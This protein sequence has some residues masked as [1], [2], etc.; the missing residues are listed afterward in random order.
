MTFQTSHADRRCEHPPRLGALL[1]G[2]AVLALVMGAGVA[3]GQSVIGNG[4]AFQGSATSALGNVTLASTSNTDTLT[5]H[6]ST[7]IV[8]WT[9]YDN[10][11][12]T[13]P[14]S[15]LPR[16]STG[17][18]QNGSEVSGFTVLNR[19]NPASTG[20]PIEF[21]GHVVSQ[22]VDATGAVSRGGNVWFY[23]PGGIIIG[24]TGVFDVGSLILTTNAINT[25]GDTAL[26]T[27]TSGLSFTGAGG[28]TS[29]ITLQPG[30]QINQPV[31][32]SYL[33][34]VAP[35]INQGG[36]VMVNG[37]VGYVAAEAAD[38]T[39][40]AGLFDITSLIG[41]TVAAGG[42]TTLSHTGTTTG[43]AEAA[44][45][46]NAIYM[47]AIPANDAV[48]MLVSGTV[49]YQAASTAT[50]LN[51]SIVLRAGEGYTGD[52]E[53]AHQSVLLGNA[54]PANVSIPGGTFTSG[55]DVA[56]TGSLDLTTSTGNIALANFLSLAYGGVTLHVTN[57]R[58]L[59]STDNLS[60]ISI[61]QDGD[62]L[63]LSVDQGGTLNVAN[64]LSA[65][66]GNDADGQSLTFN[67]DGSATL[68]GLE[69]YA[70]RFVGSGD[71]AGGTATLNV[72]GSLTA[73]TVDFTAYGV[74]LGTGNATGGVAHLAV[75]GTAAIGDLTLEA[76]TQSYRGASTQTGG[77]AQGGTALV[78]VTGGGHLTIGDAIALDGSADAPSAM[79]TTGGIAQINAGGGTIDISNPD[80]T[81]T[82]DAS[83][84]GGS[85]RGGNAS[86]LS[87]DGGA[88]ST[89]GN[90]V[91]T[92]SAS[93]GV[94]AATAATGGSARIAIMAGSL[95]VDGTT[96]VDAQGLATNASAV[97]AA[98][99]NDAIGGVAS[100]SAGG[101]SATASAIFGGLVTLTASAIAF[102]GPAVAT[103][104]ATGGS[105]ALS[106]NAGGALAL[107]AG[108]QADSSATANGQGFDPGIVSTAGTSS[109]SA[110]G[111]SIT[112]GASS[113]INLV[114]DAFGG[115]A[116]GGTASLLV[117]DGGSITTMGTTRLEA[118]GQG[119]SLEDGSIAGFA[120]LGGTAKI[121]AL[122]GT[123][124]L[125]SV[126]LG[127]SGD[128]G[129]SSQF[130][131]GTGTGG[132]ASISA[133]PGGQISIVFADLAP[134]GVAGSGLTGA[135][136][137]VGGTSS[138]TAAGG[139]IS[140]TGDDDDGGDSISAIA[141][142][143]G[144]TA[145]SAGGVPSAGG[146]GYG[147]T[148]TMTADQ[149]GSI[150]IA[151][152]AYLSPYA[153]GG[154]SSSGTGGA[155]IGGTVTLAA[156]NSD[157]DPGTISFGSMLIDTGSFG[158]FGSIGGAA[159]AG[160]ST[161]SVG[162]GATISG[163]TLLGQ[164]YAYGGSGSSG[165]GGAAQGGSMTVT[166]DGGTLALT[167]DTNAQALTLLAFANG[168]LGGNLGG[169]GD[170]NGS[171]A[172]VM[173][174]S[175]T[176]DAPEI[177]ITAIATGGTGGDGVNTIGGNGGAA[178]GGSATMTVM[179]GAVTT[180]ALTVA[181][182][183]AGG[184]GGAGSGFADDPTMPTPV[185]AGFA[186]GSGGASSSGAA[187]VYLSGGTLTAANLVV[188]ASTTGGDGNTGGDGAGSDMTAGPALGGVGGA[189]GTATLNAA[190]L[191]IAGGT[192]TADATTVSST[193][194]GGTG[195]TGGLSGTDPVTG[196]RTQAASGALG[197]ARGGAA[198]IETDESG[199]AS[200]GAV[201]MTAGGTIG[202]TIEAGDIILAA[203]DSDG[204]APAT[205]LTL[206]SLNATMDANLT[207]TGDFVQIAAT[208]PIS[209]TG[210]AAISGF[211]LSRFDMTGRGK[212]TIGGALSDN[213][214]EVI[215]TQTAPTPGTVAITAGSAQIDASFAGVTLAGLT[216]TIGDL[217]L[218]AAQAI[219]ATDLVSAA[220][221][222]LSAGGSIGLNSLTA[223]RDI[224]IEA[225]G[226]LSATMLTSTHGAIDAEPEGSSAIT[227]V[228]AGG[229]IEI[230]AGGA[231]RYGTVTGGT[232]PASTEN[233]GGSDFGSVAL[234]AGGDLAIDTGVSAYQSVGLVAGGALSAPSVVA[235]NGG[236]VG[237]I[238]GGAITLGTVTAP[239]LFYVGGPVAIAGLDPDASAAEIVASLQAEGPVASGGA[240]TITGAQAGTA[241]IDAGTTLGIAGTLG[242][243]GDAT[244]IAGGAINAG[245]LAIGGSLNLTGQST[246]TLG[247]ATAG[248]DLMIASRDDISVN[249]AT[250]GRDAVIY[251]FIRGTDTDLLSRGV[252]VGSVTAG[253][254]VAL[255]AWGR[256]DAGSII[257]TGLG[258]DGTTPGGYA[259]VAGSG[260]LL[261]G[262]TG[263]HV[264]SIVAQS[265][266]LADN[267]VETING[268]EQGHGT[269]GVALD[270]VS[271]RGTITLESDR[272]TVNATIVAAGPITATGT[273]VTLTA[274][275]ASLQIAQVTASNGDVTI[276]AGGDLTASGAIVSTTGDVD[277][278][279]GG[280]VDIGAL[281]AGDTATVEAGTALHA[282]SIAVGTNTA[283]LDNDG[284]GVFG[285]L[286]L[287]AGDAI[288]VDTPFTVTGS[289]GLVSYNAGI[290]L[291]SLTAGTG[292][293]VAVLAGGD[294][295]LGTVSAPNL[296]YVGGPAVL[297]SLGADP[298]VTEI[299]GLLGQAGTVASGGAVTIGQATAGS[300]RI[301]A[302]T[303]LTLSGPLATTVGGATLAATG[304]LATQDVTAAGALDAT[305]SAGAV[306]MGTVQA[307]S[308]AIAAGAT[309]TLGGP[310]TATAG[311][312]TLA[313]AG[314][315]ATHDVTATGAV[316][317][318]S[319]GGA[320][321]VGRVTAGQPTIAGG[322]HLTAMQ[323][324]T[325]GTLTGS[326]SI[327]VTSAAAGLAL[328]DVT[329]SGGGVTAM[330]GGGDIALGTVRAAGSITIAGPDR[331]TA[332]DLTAGTGPLLPGESGGG[333]TDPATGGIATGFDGTAIAACDDC[334]TDS[335]AL[336]FALNYF[337]QSYTATYVSNNGYLTF[338]QGQ[339]TYTPSG[340]ASGYS[341]LPIVAAFF[342]DVDTRGEGSALSAY[343]SGTFAGRQAFGATWNGVGYFGAHAD[344]LDNF[345]IILTNRSDTGAGNFDIYYN[346]TNIGWETG[347]ASGGSNGLGGISAA[348]GYNAGTGN[349]PGTFYQLAGSLVPGSFINGGTAPLITTTN[350]GIAGQLLFQVRN[351]Q[352]STVASEP[353]SIHVSNLSGTGTSDIQLGT[354]SAEGAEVHGTGRV[355]VGNVDV[356][357]HGSGISAT[358]QP[359]ATVLDAGLGLQAGTVSSTGLIALGSRS[360][361][362]S[363]GTITGGASV[364]VL[365]DGSVALG[366]V[367]T[368]TTANDS[369]YIGGAATDALTGFGFT[370][371]LS[372]TGF[373]PATLASA[374]P[375]PAGGA[376]SVA[377]PIATGNLR[378]AANG[379]ISLAD[380]NATGTILIN[381]GA[382]LATGA[383][384]AAGAITASGQGDVTLGAT[385]AGSVTATSTGGA[386]TMG[387]TVATNAVSLAAAGTLGIGSVDGTGI[388]LSSAD[389]AI[390]SGAA[391]GSSRT[392]TLGFVNTGTGRTAI[393]DN[394]G[395]T[396]GDYAL[397]AAELAT[398]HAN[399]ITIGPAMVRDGTVADTLIGDLTL[400]GT[401]QQGGNLIGSKAG[402]TVASPGTIRIVGAARFTGLAASDTVTLASTGGDVTGVLPAGSVVLDNGSGALAGTLALAGRT[403]LFATPAAAAA[404]AAATTPAAVDAALG[405][406]GTLA[407]PAGYLRADTVSLRFSNALYTQ[408]SGASTALDDRAGITGG[409]GGIL[410]QPTTTQ[411]SQPANLVLNARLEQGGTT[412][413]GDQVFRALALQPSGF[414]AGATLNS[415]LLDASNC[416]V[417]TTAPDA[418]AVITALVQSIQPVQDVVSQVRL[419]SGLGNATAYSFTSPA[420]ITTIDLTTPTLPPEIDEPVTG[421]GNES[422]WV[423]IGIGRELAPM[424]GKPADAPRP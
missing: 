14:I 40:N 411:A 342:A 307:G 233:D 256:L 424:G 192:V 301:A 277:L 8:D 59:T 404:V 383:L 374:T 268:V 413:V 6:S 80:A 36:T 162:Q 386:L 273:S 275:S 269:G 126:D 412:L 127:A 260:V 219:A 366:Q 182:I 15:F 203:N 28:S 285:S 379:A 194:N 181:T 109:I 53:G 187:G 264:G 151:R 382:R 234:V 223:A 239:N 253:D 361:D 282:G 222:T 149:G 343:G 173:V 211:V 362:V 180:S 246:A 197:D 160:T 146:I 348:V 410:L 345:Q 199:T 303:M 316:S 397:S 356:G 417:T 287:I 251:T 24:S 161:V 318:A 353:P 255:G 403:I 358:G 317:A 77:T 295:R 78:D 18:F 47:V 330:A 206:D 119:G 395:A 200:L 331:I 420:L 259:D 335:I 401:A 117:A 110:N 140:F 124:S 114:S 175:G 139:T 237:V 79:A 105:A 218:S 208:A 373:D 196:M 184:T 22:L 226:A 305:S 19:I 236:S 189:G 34:I 165:A 252:R 195:G 31:N 20:R 174:N 153:T 381:G 408:N 227:T 310:L 274:P 258:Q 415:C 138:I 261:Y 380:V 339:G 158:G 422:L 279:A 62:P 144:S 121:T 238:A 400:R 7:A 89:A 351:G 55:I 75:T 38:I 152:G 272:D 86:L 26:P 131:G 329:S 241:T 65:E 112:A 129:G 286:A 67:I 271:A 284:S 74:T 82:I 257:T 346:Y 263:I 423:N 332:G 94:G 402:F 1:A 29:A 9:P 2:T 393:G 122:S 406:P 190:T 171:N 133:M 298:T 311:G 56:T 306:T 254:D 136:N 350:D 249:S 148:V 283:S 49:G 320:V 369:F 76:G 10:A 349:Q 27:P 205:P 177:K 99:G 25:A 164:T 389:I 396:A 355:T 170:A 299:V 377:G 58:S 357:N 168:G 167:G 384:N 278:S 372:G 157:D 291:A 359:Y 319:S 240:V 354:L 135:A 352:V 50:Q 106:A 328:Q 294:I 97:T 315:L 83:A 370:S 39:I 337:G 137:G 166:V 66:R 418:N 297:S 231:A 421:A 244:L 155:A 101:V 378:A 217:D 95:E 54:Q 385:T 212:L 70:G 61:Q 314:D 235:A 322:I 265:S 68:G 104:S 178:T 123:I 118:D 416:G 185:Q 57:G 143:T 215:G 204:T 98:A 116:T 334:S 276:D 72:A 390:A 46:R 309:L 41:S 296:L 103:G 324:V 179:D 419:S 325:A 321:T 270:S 228:S 344:K 336:P 360:G 81:A 347:D 5:I 96:M 214:L 147:G 340:L 392:A 142:G 183:A 202:G 188:T 33:A 313:S 375:V 92:G 132:T 245:T 12:G 130:E 365:A 11:A 21:D 60:L 266:V 387:T 409:S 93:N 134:N 88:I 87:Q 292:G 308:A 210:D 220:N 376:I 398:A 327:G 163:A 85:A 333:A 289:I 186:G 229:E 17:I 367:T 120:G 221:A 23:A 73:N 230:T 169:G 407:N 302:G 300:A 111:G 107:N 247:T 388:T 405:D 13:G 51:G 44:G 371:L 209:I 198:T 115:T 154:A 363:A 323:A 172:A 113:G 242:T 368:G 43:P 338:N 201:V 64:Y 290:D 224:D 391:I 141:D 30:A 176:L 288:T 37:S 48:T 4:V 250:A 3:R 32:G 45:A 156:L 108:L 394:S 150:S 280:L 341:G 364:M 232:D 326:G 52:P 63:T 207:S 262:G 191:S 281:S 399:A 84:T 193:T 102:D 91:V 125:G 248:T 145:L 243:S 414:V 71:A 69:L 35:R 216:T 42:E 225:G 213:T 293:S 304:A 128:G 267:F 100:I 90:L 312:V 16:G 159:T